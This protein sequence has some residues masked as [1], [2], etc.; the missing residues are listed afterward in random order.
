MFVLTKPLG[1]D[2][3][4]TEEHQEEAHRLRHSAPVTDTGA[5]VVVADAIA[6]TE[7]ELEEMPVACARPGKRGKL[8]RCTYTRDGSNA[9]GRHLI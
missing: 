9:A 7:N 2:V 5:D 4:A 8:Q 6:N 3:Q 1:F